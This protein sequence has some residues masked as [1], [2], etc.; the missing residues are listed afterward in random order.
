MESKCGPAA[1][2]RHDVRSSRDAGDLPGGQ[3]HH[4]LSPIRNHISAWRTIKAWRSTGALNLDRPGPRRQH[5]ENG[6]L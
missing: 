4:R 6:E 2:L 5:R 1:G 3:N